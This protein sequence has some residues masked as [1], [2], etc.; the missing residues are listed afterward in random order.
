MAEGWR[1]Y[2]HAMLPSTPP[3]ESVNMKPI[4]D[5]SIWNIEGYRPLLA[6]WTTDFDCGYET[7]WWYCILDKPFDLSNIKAKRRYEINKG[8]KKFYVKKINPREYKEAIYN[9][10]IEAYKAYPDK[11]RPNI[12]RNNVFCDIDSW[13]VYAYYG[14][15]K[16]EDNSFCGYSLINRDGKYM[17]YAIHKVIPQYERDGIN[18]A[19]VYGFL[20]DQKD[21]LSEGGYICDGSRNIIHETGFQDYLEKYFL[22]RKAYCKLNIK[23]RFPLNLI[24]K[25]TYPLKKI[26]KKLDNNKTVHLLN[27]LLAMEEVANK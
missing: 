1:Y 14:V 8:L 24:I 13:E 17:Y 7:E 5:G 23:Y 15:F 2:N 4:E 10:Q 26:L 27:G 16:I 21:F 3:H 20:E 12:D 9:V 6:R 18:A 25:I 19:L 22:F 11:Y